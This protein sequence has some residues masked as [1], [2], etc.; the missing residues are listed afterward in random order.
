LSP[1]RD[2]FGPQS[3]DLGLGLGEFDVLDDIRRPIL[4]S[5]PAMIPIIAGE[6]LVAFPAPRLLRSQQVAIGATQGPVQR[7][8]FTETTPEKPIRTPERPPEFM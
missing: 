6:L 4:Q 7:P 5:A 3:H 1:Q 2:Q 8:Q